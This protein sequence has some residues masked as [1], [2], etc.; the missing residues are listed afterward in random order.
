M[1][2]A[3]SKGCV[4]NW[5]R[6]WRMMVY[7][8]LQVVSGN[9]GKWAASWTTCMYDLDYWPTEI[10]IP[11]TRTAEASQKS[12]FTALTDLVSGSPRL[13]SRPNSPCLVE[14][15]SPCKRLRHQEFSSVKIMHHIYIY[16]AGFVDE[17]CPTDDS[18]CERASIGE[19]SNT[20]IVEV[21]PRRRPRPLSFAR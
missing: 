21:C 15:P 18:I 7:Q 10:G 2:I 11:S 19:S 3:S 13:P 1:S 14:P 17:V 8:L 6:L 9:V 5:G 4:L 12:R 20:T 16:A